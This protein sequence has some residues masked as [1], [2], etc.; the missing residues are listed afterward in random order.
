VPVS[1]YWYLGALITAAALEV[2][3]IFAPSRR[4][5]TWLDDVVL[6]GVA[7]A[8]NAALTAVLRGVDQLGS[9]NAIRAI[10]WSTI[11][12]LL[13]ARRFRHLLTY[14][15]VLIAVVTTTGSL[16][17][18]LGRMRPT[19]V[20]M[21]VS[22]RGYSHPS[23]AV[24]IFAAVIAGAV[25]TLVPTGRWRR[26]GVLAGGMLVLLFGLTRIYLGVDHPSDVLAALAIGWAFSAVAYRLV[27]PE[28]VFAVR[29]RHRGNPAHLDLSG[30][31]G[32]A[33]RR[34]LE[35]QLGI[36]ATSIEPF[37]LE[38]SAGST[39]LRIRT[40]EQGTLFG[41]LYALNHLRSDR[42][43]K[44]ARMVLYGRLEDEK[45]F[46]T[47]RRLVEYEDHMLRL[48]RDNGLPVPRPHGFVEITPEREYVIVM[49]FVDGARDL[50]AA[51]VG[52]PEIDDG[53]RIVRKLWRAGVA[54][55]DIKPSNLL[56][57]DRHV[58]LIDVAFATVRPTPW[59]QAVDLSNMMLTLAL[60][61]DPSLVY[62][63]A[64]SQFAPED[65]AE[66]F[67]A[68]RSITMPTQLR[69]R[70]RHD[71]RDLVGEFRRLAPR[72]APVPIQVWNVR[73]VAVLGAVLAASALAGV[74]LLAYAQIAGLL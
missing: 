37:S 34:A 12:L 68:A 42:S 22:W 47:V 40:T 53:L 3:M 7:S 18:A 39:P 25:Y 10:S 59:R 64:V 58:H 4:W 50:G 44:L 45:P 60:A 54:H 1:G 24:A 11:A 17:F 21:L 70:L 38:A 46:A 62:E 14:L 28:E 55:R 63:R 73:R 35:Q 23:T 36:T 66:G 8:R 30:E 15:A 2:A 74:G 43:Y 65:I 27:V 57:K 61:S 13:L 20:T 67:A 69:T 49:D 71:S 19:T 16:A 5:I 32:D 26:R 48:L 29:Y 6:D 31:R 9:S 41:K 33:V 72:R 52:E 51:P 56:V